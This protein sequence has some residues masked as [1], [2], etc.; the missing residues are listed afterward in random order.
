MFG[1]FCQKKLYDFTKCL[2]GKQ[3]NQYLIDLICDR[4]SSQHE[5]GITFKLK[6]LIFNVLFWSM[7]FI[8]ACPWITKYIDS[9]NLAIYLS[10]FRFH[11]ISNM[12]SKPI[13]PDSIE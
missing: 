3:I 7:R 2:D 11:S 5:I 8:N 4:N 9:T 13:I 10:Y 12:S 1:R 6:V